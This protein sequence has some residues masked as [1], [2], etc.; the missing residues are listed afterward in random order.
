[1]MRR[2]IAMGDLC[3]RESGE[4]F[5]ARLLPRDLSLSGCVFAKRETAF[6]MGIAVTFVMLISSMAAYGIRR[7]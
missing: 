5:C 2:A 7:Y 1:M 4:Q 6:R 3:Q